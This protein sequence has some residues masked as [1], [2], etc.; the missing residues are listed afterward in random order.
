MVWAPLIFLAIDGV[1]AAG[2]VRPQITPGKPVLLGMLAAMQIFAG[3]PQ[4][5]L[6]TAIGAGCYSLIRLCYVERRGSVATLLAAIY[7]G[8]ALLASVQLLTGMQA[9]AETIRNEPLPFRFAAEFGFSRKF[10]SPWWPPAI[11][12]EFERGASLLGTVADVGNVGIFRR[13]RIGLRDLWRPLLRKA[14]AHGFFADPGDFTGPFAGPPI[15][16]CSGCFTIICPG[17]TNSAA[18]PS[19]SF[20]LRS[21]MWPWRRT[22]LTG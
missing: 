21:C 20:R 10:P 17:S 8:G 22:G 9:N 16:R 6:F 5:V 18:C 15:R 14:G 11:F 7:I 12:W 13:H 19:S 1:F 2:D 3:Q 4:Y